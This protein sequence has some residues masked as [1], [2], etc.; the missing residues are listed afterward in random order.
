MHTFKI[1]KV[2]YILKSKVWKLNR[3]KVHFLRHF[4]FSIILHINISGLPRLL[5]RLIVIKVTISTLVTLTKIRTLP[6]RRITRTILF[7]AFSL[8]TSTRLQLIQIVNTLL[9]QLP[10]SFE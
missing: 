2:Q 9:L 5:R 1:K 10:F 8:F 6:P 4:Y 3:F 7:I